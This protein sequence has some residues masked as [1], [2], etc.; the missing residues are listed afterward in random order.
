M[1]EALEK[2][3]DAQDFYDKKK[4]KYAEVVMAEMK[5]SGIGQDRK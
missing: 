4:A 2:V 1:E 5:L 3:H